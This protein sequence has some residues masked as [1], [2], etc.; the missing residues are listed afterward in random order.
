MKCTTKTHVGAGPTMCR[1]IYSKNEEEDT[2]II[3]G[4]DT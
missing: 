4:N 1:V 3:I 2:K